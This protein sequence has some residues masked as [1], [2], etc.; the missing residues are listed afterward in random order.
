MG[1]LSVDCSAALDNGL[2]N[3]CFKGHDIHSDREAATV[4]L[5]MCPHASDDSF[6]GLGG[7]VYTYIVIYRDICRDCGSYTM[8]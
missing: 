3:A 4:L 7:L 5:H 6:Y 2:S 8:V 1:D